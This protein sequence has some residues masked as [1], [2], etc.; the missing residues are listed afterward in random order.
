MAYN[1]IIIDLL[2]T[3]S[4]AVTDLLLLFKVLK[5]SRLYNQIHGLQ[6]YMLLEDKISSFHTSFGLG[7]KSED[8]VQYKSYFTNCT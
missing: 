5:Y 2:K 6:N 4:A 7:Q 1:S 3:C 8:Y